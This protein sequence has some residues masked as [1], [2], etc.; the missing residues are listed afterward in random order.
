MKHYTVS[1]VSG[2]DLMHPPGKICCCLELRQEADHSCPSSGKVKNGGSLHALYTYSSMCLHGI[3]RHSLLSPCSAVQRCKLHLLT[4]TDKFLKL[5][6]PII[7]TKEFN[8]NFCF[9]FSLFP[10]PPIYKQE[11]STP[12]EDG[13][14]SLDSQE[15]L[16][17]LW[18]LGSLPCS[19]E[20]I[21]S[22]YPKPD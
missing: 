2:D 6:F 16:H 21:T 14:S 20:S 3:N 15:I 7:K 1:K 13:G 12:W 8:H 9:E 5:W 4:L 19:Q 10:L 18:D 11:S 22:P 17:N